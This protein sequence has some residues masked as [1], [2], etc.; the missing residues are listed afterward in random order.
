MEEKSIISFENKEIR[1]IWHNDEWYFSVVDV[2]EILTDSSQ[3]SRY[4]SDLKKRSEKESSQSFVFC[5]RL[6]LKRSDGKTYPKDCAY[7]EGYLKK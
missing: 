5:E 4:W 3:P 6:K 1:K 2:I 7:T